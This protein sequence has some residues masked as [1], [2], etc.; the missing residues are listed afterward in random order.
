MINRLIIYTILSMLIPTGCGKDNPPDGYIILYNDTG[1][2]AYAS[3]IA[4]GDYNQSLLTYSSKA[5]AIRG[6]WKYFE[7]KKE[8]ESYNNWHE[9]KENKQ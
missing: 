9:Y 5:G 3:P 6:A 8:G 7:R 4:Y 2:W 1:R